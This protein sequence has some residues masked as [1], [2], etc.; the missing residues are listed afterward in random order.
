MPTIKN[1]IEAFLPEAHEAEAQGW[2]PPE[3]EQVLVVH[4]KPRQYVAPNWQRIMPILLAKFAQTFLAARIEALE[5]DVEALRKRLDQVGSSRS[6][7]APIET[8]APEPYEATKPFHVVVEPVD[9]EFIATLFDANINASGDTAEESVS[10]LK[11][12]MLT[13]FERLQRE[14]QGKL[15]SGPARQ[16]SV[17]KSLVRKQ[18]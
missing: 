7:I 11:D 16:L 14:P 4:R 8:F 3:C 13:L 17:L 2:R 18:P 6:I 15:G 9:D 1:R 12:I 5:R 10:N